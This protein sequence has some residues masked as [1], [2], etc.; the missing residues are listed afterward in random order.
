MIKKFHQKVS[1]NLTLI[2]RHHAKNWGFDVQPDGFVPLTE[3]VNRVKYFQSLGITEEEI[4]ML[5]ENVDAKDR[6]ALRRTYMDDK[7]HPEYR[8]TSRRGSTASDGGNIGGSR[9]NSPQRT[10]VTINNPQKMVVF[11]RANQGHSMDVITDESLLSRINFPLPVC[12]HGTYWQFLEPILKE[13]LSKRNRNH[14][15]FSM[16]TLTE[17]HANKH[18]QDAAFA[19]QAT[20]LASD[21]EVD[22]LRFGGMRDDSEVSIYINMSAAMDAGIHFY[23][24]KNNVILSPGDDYGMIPSEFFERIVDNDSGRELEWDVVGE[25]TARSPKSLVLSPKKVAEP[26]PA[27]GALNVP[28]MSLGANSNTPRKKS[29]GRAARSGKGRAHQ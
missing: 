21:N 5:V 13:G 20:L 1:K 12:I 19:T 26:E 6:F 25:G 14:I 10:S 27:N 24:S 7:E 29:G 2:L 11:I 23:K 28:S 17:L 3:I 15:H 9:S 8:S 22:T 4:V 16:A 18:K